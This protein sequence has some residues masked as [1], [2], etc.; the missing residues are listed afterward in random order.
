[1]NH[2]TVSANYTNYYFVASLMC[3]SHK[4]THY[5]SGKHTVVLVESVSYDTAKL[6]N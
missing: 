3:K 4:N 1:M 2:S 6:N 5:I